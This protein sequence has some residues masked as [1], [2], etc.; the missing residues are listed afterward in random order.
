M[1]KMLTI[2]VAPILLL[3]AFGIGR[4]TAPDSAAPITNSGF[5]LAPSLTGKTCNLASLPPVVVKTPA[6]FEGKTVDELN[7]RFADNKNRIPSAATQDEQQ[8]LLEALA[9]IDPQAA[10]A[11]AQ[12]LKGDRQAQA[13]SAVLAAWGEKDPDA[14]WNWVGSTRPD[15]IYQ[16]DQ[17][18][19][20][21]GRN[22]PETA[23]RYAISLAGTRPD[24][25]QEVYLSALMGITHAGG[26]DTARQLVESANISTED[27]TTLM[28]YVAGAWASYEPQAAMQWVMAQPGELQSSALVGLGESWSNVDPQAAANFA[29]KLNGPQRQLL[30]QQSI[31][32]WLMDDPSAAT[33]W[34]ASA[35]NHQD[36]DQA[37]HSV[38]TLPNMVRDQTQTALA[39][40]ERIY[41]SNLR[42]STVQQILAEMKVKDPAGAT[43]YARSAPNL[44]AAQRTQL[45]NS[46]GDGS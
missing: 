42:V 20:V 8:H 40:S 21:F 29:S 32:K 43:S 27:R 15:N 38:A 19:E 11:Q 28:N 37:V 16:Y 30:L 44:T 18:L 25:T 31:S 24:L 33:N 7:K 46:L 14:A 23:A 3:A 22:N 6:P 1:S 17:L 41:D 4:W 5:S 36:Y 12:Q 34:L 9:A 45:L 39:W 26:Y 13:V 10:M 35:E 2:S